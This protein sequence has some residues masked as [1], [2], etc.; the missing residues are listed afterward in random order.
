MRT[1]YAEG[2][3][4]VGII[5]PTRSARR[6]RRRIYY[7]DDGIRLDMILHDDALPD[8]QGIE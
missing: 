7:T 8:S 3:T 5:N 4:H 1:G 2:V 6:Y